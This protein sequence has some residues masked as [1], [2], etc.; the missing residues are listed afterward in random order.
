MLPMEVSQEEKTDGSVPTE[1]DPEDPESFHNAVIFEDA[2][3]PVEATTQNPE[4][5]ESASGSRPTAVENSADPKKAPE[6]PVD[7][8][9]G[10]SP[11]CW[12]QTRSENGKTSVS[13]F[14][15]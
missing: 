3:D 10:G 12:S 15:A 14:Q 6:G 7:S 11:S 13:R 5:S 8:I 2:A 4:N 1:Y 9:P